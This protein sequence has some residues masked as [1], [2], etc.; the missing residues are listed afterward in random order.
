MDILHPR[1]AYHRAD[2]DDTGNQD[3]IEMLSV[4]SSKADSKPDYTEIHEYGSDYHLRA[5]DKDRQPLL[6]PSTRARWFSGWRTGA[7]SAA[8]LALFS[9]IINI[10]A[11][12][13]LK[14]HPG[15]NSN[16]VEVFNGSCDKVSNM[17]IWVHL[18]INAISTLLLGGSNYC[19]QCLC[20]P[21]R[22]EIDRAHAKGQFLD[23]GVP[24]YRNLSCIAWPRVI[25]WWIL[26]LSS[27]PLHL[28]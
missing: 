24:S 8:C 12:A 5:P 10:A 18:L 13:W 7:Y 2:T 3:G 21:N 28:M 27:I 16:L 26:G 15:A 17:D 4:Y 14:R 1:R 22:Q 19:M 20:A 25:M 23:I 11:A 9:L 6:E